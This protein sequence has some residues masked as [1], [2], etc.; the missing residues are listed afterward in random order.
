MDFCFHPRQQ[1]FDALRKIRDTKARIKGKNKKEL[2]KLTINDLFLDIFQDSI[3][4]HYDPV[5]PNMQQ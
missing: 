4:K 3:Q 1:N 2:K 5:E